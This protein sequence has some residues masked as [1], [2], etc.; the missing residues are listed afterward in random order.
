[1]KE[2]DRPG[3]YKLYITFHIRESVFLID[4]LNNT[5]KEIDAL[6]LTVRRNDIEGV[7]RMINEEDVN[8]LTYDK[9]TVLHDAGRLAGPEIVKLLLEKGAR[10]NVLDRHG[11]T[12]ILRASHDIESME[13][14]LN[15]GSDIN[16]QSEGKYGWNL[17]HIRARAGNLVTCKFLIEN[18]AQINIRDKMNK[19]PLGLAIQ[20]KNG[21]DKD[22]YPDRVKKFEKV[23]EFLKK[24]GG[25]E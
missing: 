12:P 6:H 8:E 14:L 1:M 15:H 17:L 3:T 4:T 22:K 16:R 10:V 11:Q 23:I 13:L 18:G 20:G 25:I 5:S 9:S 2:A 24:N 21:V 19:T 7:K